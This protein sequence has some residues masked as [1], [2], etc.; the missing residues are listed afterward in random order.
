MPT[1][2]IL[3]CVYPRQHPR[4]NPLP[5]RRLPSTIPSLY[6]PAYKDLTSC[7]AQARC[8]EVFSGLKVTED[9]AAYLAEATKLQSKSL[10]W[11]EHR[12]ARITASKFHTVCHTSITSP[13]R[14]LVQQILTG[15][16]VS[17]AAI[18]WGIQNETVAVQEFKRTASLNH[19][20]FALKFTGLHINPKFLHLGASPDGLVSCECCGEGLLEVK[21]PYSIRHISPTSADTPR[22]FYLKHDKDGTLRLSPTH[23]YYYQ[24]QEQMAVCERK[25]TY[26][27]CWTTH[28]L[29]LER[30]EH[31]KLFFSS[32]KPRLDNFFLDVILP[33]VLRG[34][35]TDSDSKT[36]SKKKKP[37]YCYCQREDEYDDMIECDNP[38]CTFGWFHFS[39]V[40]IV[41]PPD[42]QWFCD[43]CQNT[44]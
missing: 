21:C 3:T 11:Y 20:S 9:E 14:S 37:L 4:P 1:S 30:I 26:F 25:Y 19:T 41:T 29:H 6:Q 27:V 39:C 7:D 33:A 38:A 44:V 42:G 15:G 12:R 31:D 34:E 2:A 16:N 8:R 35:S 13:S 5:L 22:D 24:V 18:A 23:M 28:G 32:I 43:N 40:G 36:L 10:L 17:S